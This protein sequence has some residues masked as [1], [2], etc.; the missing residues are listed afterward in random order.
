M[1]SLISIIIPVYND[2]QGL[3]NTL[4]SLVN[5]E[6]NK[7]SYEIIVADNGSNDATLKIAGK[8]IREYPNLIKICEEDKIQSSYA[9]RNK[10]ILSST[11]EIIVFIDAD[12]IVEPGCL[13][14]IQKIMSDKKI[15]YAGLNVDLFLKRK[16]ISGIYDK[17][18]GFKIEDS[19]KYF[20]YFPTCGLVTRRGIFNK[21][22]FFD[23]RLISGGD[24]VFGKRI[25]LEGY[26]QFFLKDIKIM[27]P[28][29]DNIKLLIQKYLRLG[30]GVFQV[31][32]YYP[33]LR[34]KKKNLFLRY[35]LPD[36]PDTFFKKF[37][38]KKKEFNFPLIYILVFY[39]IKW[40]LGIAKFRGYIIEKK[41]ITK[42]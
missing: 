7:S 30:R 34:K 22:G 24:R 36:R 10:G 12:V 4:A 11:G 23:S 2:P 3:L 41:L 37:L 25:K 13:T 33:H 31:E 38:K 29:R 39:F 1:K 9:A 5:Q 28:P 6:F 17:I 35:L 16:S 8:F 32:Y 15:Q 27:H 42:K 14:K 18:I 26:K 20:Y 21:I 19:L 40:I